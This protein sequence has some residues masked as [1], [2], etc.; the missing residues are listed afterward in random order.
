MKFAFIL[1]QFCKITICCAA[2]AAGVM[3]L[4]AAGVSGPATAQ[5]ETITD[6]VCYSGSQ[7]IYKGSGVLQ[8]YG[9]VL[10]LKSG[11]D[12]IYLTGHCVARD[13]L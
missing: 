7:R 11:K 9:S 5:A 1:V 10:R 3:L 6:V 13:R 8:I 2:V 4:K 12:D